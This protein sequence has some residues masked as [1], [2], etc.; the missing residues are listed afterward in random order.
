[1]LRKD[2]NELYL[3][4]D[5]NE[6]DMKTKSKEV[7]SLN[8]TIDLKDKLWNQLK[9]QTGVIKSDSEVMK[10]IG[11]IAERQDAGTQ[12]TDPEIEKLRGQITQLQVDAT[13]FV[14]QI[15][16]ENAIKQ[17]SSD[18]CIHDL[19]NENRVLTE[20]NSKLKKEVDWMITVE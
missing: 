19:E 4:L 10:I 17:V 8:W 2:I 5:T 13:S 14:K 1:M 20:E 7:E 11:I 9:E 15:S 16:Y 3:K 6:I 18:L 12:C